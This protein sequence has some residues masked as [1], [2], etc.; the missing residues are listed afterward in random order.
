MARVMM[1]STAEKS[2]GGITSVIKLIKRMPV[3]EKYSCYWLSTQIQGSIIKKLWYA[4]TAA[5]KAPFIMWQYDIIHFHMVPG[6]N[7]FVQLP[8]LIIAK[9]Y[10]KKIITEVHVGN[11]LVPYSKSKFFRW[12]LKRAHLVLLLAHKWVNLFHDVYADI[13]TP[14]DVLYNACDSH[15]PIPLE[16]KKK[17]ITFVGTM[18][19]NKAP[20]LLL[21][22]W[23]D[24]KVKYPDWR[25]LFLGQGDIDK[26]H[27]LADELKVSN[28]VE[29][30]GQVSG[31]S[32]EQ[33]FHDASIYCMC[34]YLEGF[35]M[36]V[37]EAWAHSTA[38]VTT[39]VG[40][41]PDVIEDGKNCLT[42]PFGDYKAL[43]SQLEK[44]IGNDNL[45]KNV[46]E[47][48]YRTAQ[49]HFSLEKVNSALVNIYNKVMNE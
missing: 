15:V 9:L 34:S 12:W 30:M 21:R 4:I 22:A 40:G 35:P 32:K 13:K 8:E 7:L 43:A 41:L 20:D 23:A 18:D 39:P 10:G 19:D 5:I 38:V 1:V 31:E 42:F 28:V 11:Q 47:C 26:F 33:I 6:I 2:G 3:W 27:R 16:G 44:L 46:S 14:V 17:I 48:G 36:A 45:R 49:E 37:L 24:L 29:F 25:V